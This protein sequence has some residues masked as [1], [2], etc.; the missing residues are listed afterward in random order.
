MS[1][2]TQKD[3]KEKCA[4]GQ[5]REPVEE[6]EEEYGKQEVVIVDNLPANEVVVVDDDAEDVDYDDYPDCLLVVDLDQPRES[7]RM[8]RHAKETW[9]VGQTR[10][11][12]E[13][14]N[15]EVKSEVVIV[16][17]LPLNEVVVVDD[18]DDGCD[19]DHND[20]DN[21]EEA[22]PV[23]CVG[24]SLLE[25]DLRKNQKVLYDLRSLMA[26]GQ[27]MTARVTIEGRRFAVLKIHDDI[28]IDVVFHSTTEAGYRGYAALMSQAEQQLFLWHVVEM[29]RA[30][31]DGSVMFPD[32]VK[33]P[34]LSFTS[35]IKL[36]GFAKTSN[37]ED[38]GRLFDS[39]YS[40]SH[41][42]L[43]RRLYDKVVEALGKPLRSKLATA[44]AYFEG[45]DG[46]DSYLDT[47]LFADWGDRR[48]TKAT[49]KR[50]KEAEKREPQQKMETQ[51]E[52]KKEEKEGQP[53]KSKK[54]KVEVLVL[55]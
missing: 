44:S 39:N 33:V 19:D 27:Q 35:L 4:I 2:S 15:E 9:A 38:R 23:F 34:T 25:A 53:T 28:D 3:D 17:N 29:V 41:E 40:P 18:C 49:I 45:E 50:V 42:L 46:L 32:E 14:E 10:Q 1:H 24:Q 43:P 11:L 55:D 7:R 13:E 26:D 36:G 31:K 30:N 16:E 47:H 48:S 21:G 52:E 51:Q 6:E 8:E 22:A 5:T 12:G 37:N 54:R 20:Y